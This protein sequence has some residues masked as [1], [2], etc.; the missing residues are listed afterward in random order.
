MVLYV[1]MAVR[2]RA[3]IFFNYGVLALVATKDYLY[4]M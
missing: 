4:I 3:V 2:I 1:R